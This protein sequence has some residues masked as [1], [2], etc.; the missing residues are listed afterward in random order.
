MNTGA[1]LAL[2]RLT[3]KEN[4]R[5]NIFHVIALLTITVITGASL[6]TFFSF[7][8]QLKIMRDLAMAGMMV[9]GC[10]VAVILPTSG[11]RGSIETRLLHP[12][13]ARPINRTTVLLGRYLGHL[14]TIYAGLTA[15]AIVFSL[16]IFLF[17]RSLDTGFI[18]AIIY[19]YLEAALLAGIATLF[20]ALFSPALAVAFSMTAY[21]LGSIKIGFISRILE[22]SDNAFAKA[23]LSVIYHILPNL[24]CFNFKD[25]LVHGI[26]VPS[27]YLAWVAF[28]GALYTTAALW[29]ASL[30]LNSRDL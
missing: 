16:Q 23:F 4:V 20:S 26:P 24:E 29:L 8:T 9:G 28:Y 13:F 15:M 2:A 21:L 3:L 12:I 22:K 18:I 5:K 27:S 19:V 25:A 7:G 14:I 17:Q 1:I 30:A 6:L 10:L 11:L